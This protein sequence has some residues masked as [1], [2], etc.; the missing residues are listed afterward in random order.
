MSCSLCLLFLNL[1]VWSGYRGNYVTYIK[2]Q[3][4]CIYYFHNSVYWKIFIF[5]YCLYSCLCDRQYIYPWRSFDFQALFYII[6]RKENCPESKKGFVQYLDRVSNHRQLVRVDE[7]Y[8]SIHSLATY[9]PAFKTNSSSTFV[10]KQYSYAR[11]S[12]DQ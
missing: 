2:L 1:L 11:S 4:Y 8:V 12:Y 10:L 5:L 6:K 7:N 3:I 9:R